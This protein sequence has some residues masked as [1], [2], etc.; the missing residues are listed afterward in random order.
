MISILAGILF[1]ATLGFV[2]IRPRQL[3]E[4]WGAAAGGIGMLLL[5]AVS[6]REASEIAQNSANILLF[7]VGMMIVSA[8]VE[9]AGFFA[10][11]ATYAAEWARGNG[12]LLYLNVFL[13]G[14]V[15]TAIFSLD[16]TVI[17]LT[18][19]VYS[20]VSRLRLNPLPF[21][22]ACTFVANTAS[23]FLP[24][25]NLTNILVYELLDIPFWE[26]ARYMLLPNLAALAINVG[27]FFFI[28]RG[29]LPARFDRKSLGTAAACIQHPGFFLTCT[30][31]LVV[32]MAALFVSGL[33]N[34]PLYPVVLIGAAWLLALGWRTR[35]AE[36][37]PVLR[38]VSWTLI[39]F[40]LG[41]FLVMRGVQNTLIAP[42]LGS[43]LAAIRFDNGLT[44]ILATAGLTA[45]GSNIINNVPMTLVMLT[46]FRSL[47]GHLPYG[48]TLG[49][50]LGVNLGPNLTTF[51][52]LATMLWLAI[53]RKRGQEISAWDYLRIGIVVTPAMLLAAGVMLWLMLQGL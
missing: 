1:V 11:A 45:L 39:V 5:G 38:D 35:Q 28:F 13:L 7:L 16:V 53:V 21:M 50:V 3:N 43:R 17:I 2:I 12:W 8:V 51:G 23:L 10:W 15:I 32:L 27:F 49:T 42:L 22:F 20:F 29:A 24:I 18:P 48:L 40:V 9:R 41:M 47:G 44:T 25:S 14:T 4:A 31:T 30:L 6:L 37:L 36:P 26:F 46:T 19:I 52:S 34:W 33:R